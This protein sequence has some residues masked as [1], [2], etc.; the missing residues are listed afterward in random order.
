MKQILKKT[1]TVSTVIFSFL[2]FFAIFS[3]LWIIFTTH[4][5]IHHEIESVPTTDVTLVLGTSRWLA[6]GGENPYF[7]FRME[8]AAQLYKK[9]KTRHFILSG[10][11]RTMYYNE[12]IEMKK[13]L[14]KLDVP[15]KAITLDYAGLRTL[16]SIVRSNKIFGQDQL[17]I[18][19]QK[20]HSYRALFISRYYN[21]NVS[22]FLARD[23][24]ASKSFSVWL[25]EFFARPKAVLDLYIFH[26]S[27]RFLGER[28]KFEI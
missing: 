21:L 20:F 22:A 28:E 14:M 8:A 9:G 26:T 3:N 18:V 12:P 23:L 27:P 7:K 11:N 6:G 5:K 16:D 24:D 15:E 4:K 19:T 2:L 17:I 10:D 1:L 25:R 13:A